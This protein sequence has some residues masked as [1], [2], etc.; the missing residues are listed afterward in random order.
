MLGLGGGTPPAEEPQQRPP[1]TTTTRGTNPSSLSPH[2][3]T[4]GRWGVGSEYGVQVGGRTRPRV[5]VHACLLENTASVEHS[6][7][8]KLQEARFQQL[9]FAQPSEAHL[10]GTAVQLA[11]SSINLYLGKPGVVFARVCAPTKPRSDALVLWKE[12]NRA[13]VEAQVVERSS[14]APLGGKEHLEEGLTKVASFF[15]SSSVT[16]RAQSGKPRGESS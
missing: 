7:R 5:T 8:P 2:H 9:S 6:G 15:Q 1:P 4:L 16:G 11:S 3:P 12:I 10:E 13:V 14:S